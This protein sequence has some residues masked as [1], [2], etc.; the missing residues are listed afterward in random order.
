M[1][2]N[3]TQYLPGESEAIGWFVT[4]KKALFLV[5][6]AI[7][8]LI[9]VI[10]F[11]YYYGPN[12][13]II[14]ITAEEGD[15]EK[16][17]KENLENKEEKDI[18]LP[19]SLRPLH[20]KLK[21]HPLLDEPVN[22]FTYTGQ[23]QIH[24]TC[25]EETNEIVLNWHET[26]NIDES[27]I[28]VKHKRTEEL[29][30]TV[31]SEVQKQNNENSNNTQDVLI[32]PLFNDTE[33]NSTLKYIK[34]V[35]TLFDTSGGSIKIDKIVKDDDNDKLKIILS[36][37]LKLN[38]NYTIDV[39]F[40]GLIFDNLKG[41]FR[42][43][44]NNS[45]GEIRELVTTDF[46]PIYARRAFPCFDEPSYKSTFELSLARRNHLTALSN[47]PLKF[48]EPMENNTDWFWDHFETTPPMS[49]YLLAFTISDFDY[50]DCSSNSSLEKNCTTP[51]IKL[52]GPKLDLAKAQF[53][54]ESAVDIIEYLE[55]YFEIA[56]P[57]PKLDLIILPNLGKSASEN[58]GHVSFSK[59]WILLDEIND[60][61]L[62]KPVI[63]NLIAKKLIQQWFGN[64]V[65]MKWWSHLW[66]KEGFANLL[67]AKIER[68][69]RW[70]WDTYLNIPLTEIESAL[71][72]DSL[73][74]SKS[75]RSKITDND[76][77][78]Q[79]TETIDVDDKGSSLLRMLNYTVT[80]S[81]F[82]E[83]LQNYLRT[84]QY[85]SA[86]QDEFWAAITQTR[87]ATI[88]GD[89]NLKTIMDSWTS[90]RGYPK[91]FLRQD[92]NRY[93]LS[94][95]KFGEEQNSTESWFV[96][97]TYI[98]K[99]NNQVQNTWLK[100][101]DLVIESQALTNT[102]WILINVRM[103][104]FYRVNYDLQNW[105]LLKLQ[106]EADRHKI[107]LTNRAQLLDDAFEL[108]KIGDLNYSV[109]FGLTNFLKYNESSYVAWYPA[110]N[111][112]KYIK[113]IMDYHEYTG[114]YHTFL[115][116]LIARR[117]NVLGTSPKKD[118]SL[119]DK[120]LR[121]EIINLACHL[122]YEPCID[123][124]K[125]QLKKWMDQP[126]PD[127]NNPIHRDYRSI[128]QCMAIKKGS[129][130]EWNFLWDRT[131][132][133]NISPKDLTTIYLTLGCTHDPWLI[134]KYLHMSLQ[135]NI[136]LG[137]VP[138]V[139]QSLNHPVG[140]R[141][142]F[143]F[144]R[145]NWD[146]IYEKYND[147]FFVIKTII[148]DF[149]SNLATEIDL[150]DLTRFYKIHQADLENYATVMQETVNKIKLRIE[151]KKVHLNPVINWLNKNR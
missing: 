90:Q 98:T 13:K 37:P 150:E 139:W 56:F 130:R 92:K 87:N 132:N 19:K 70:E 27:S 52:W 144:L 16:I 73:N 82:K 143:P 111:S 31:V 101:N 5:L 67:A 107:P 94:Q 49:T 12:R 83:A 80:Q 18:R 29:I 113:T 108:A 7:L 24:V 122:Y 63:F 10:L 41:I 93:I 65:T 4:T 69:L 112:L 9:F 142:A 54:Y 145:M 89:E 138:L 102:S 118:E 46:Q 141:T 14:Q 15:I 136:S 42:S 2:S 23:V 151:W 126:D 50:M 114:V 64:L 53:A 124:A 125:S 34:G 25:K 48:S 96:P 36:N 57:L 60:S 44:Y 149:L 68:D 110:L 55:D 116:N 104:G 95:S 66:L 140:L 117:F 129:R 133:P 32:A 22:N 43:S 134:N 28:N 21:L 38:D 26:L 74:S 85:K 131:F 72:L 47:M 137:N 79:I 84:F 40:R 147:I 120:M 106:L 77:I 8:T 88:L 146:E 58:W 35:K 91:V 30:Q 119:N 33:Y 75:I 17:L 3:P 61:H 39:K 109:P 123:W 59:S 62:L 99:E 81:V 86:G 71:F 103:T 6:V 76:Q 121:L 51:Q 97:I 148:N 11:M 100:S 127:H 1:N 20:Y 105:K 128:V 45:K 135:G 78:E 115:I